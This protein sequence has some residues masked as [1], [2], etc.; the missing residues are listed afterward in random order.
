MARRRHARRTRAN[1]AW[2][3]L[4]TALSS[5]FVVAH[6]DEGTAARLDRDA[7]IARAR[8]HAPMVLDALADDARARAGLVEAERLSAQNPS[9]QGRAGPRFAPEGVLPDG[10]LMLYVPV[11]LVVDRMRAVDAARADIAAR[12]A[13]IER[14]RL[15]A[16]SM[17]ETLYI[18]VL[19]ATA[20]CAL[21]DERHELSRALVATSEAREQ[22]GASSLLDVE[23]ARTERALA[24]AEGHA[25]RARREAATHALAR[26]L[27]L[28][29][30][31]P[32][33][34]V[35]ALALPSRASAE[36]PVVDESEHP[37]VIAARAEAARARSLRAKAALAWLPSVS[38]GAG[39]AYEEGGHIPSVALQATLPVFERG[40]GERAR[41]E[42]EQT[43]R[44]R[45]AER[46][47]R[48]LVIDVERARAADAHAYEAAR[49]LDQ[50]AVLHATRALALADVAYAAGKSDVV[51]L[52]AVRR[53]ALAVRAE[54]LARVRDAAQADVDLALALGITARSTRA[55][56]EETSG[57][58]RSSEEER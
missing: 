39:Y 53:H 31:A 40:Q 10:E 13:D 51:A 45:E 9:L 23:L 33:D 54:H 43:V 47:A 5:P 37:S 18:D 1:R 12:E 21:A 27:D 24:E 55:A 52:L 35:G 11:P 6:D 3:A 15:V 14:A 56:Q 44:A 8:A 50:G 58:R 26:A 38:L 20:V 32:D 30:L 28:P 36:E 46:T 49:A 48:A 41:A 4:L 42:V 7:V 19:H 2:L 57:A 34:V 25:A 29:T 16:S 17:A 22:A